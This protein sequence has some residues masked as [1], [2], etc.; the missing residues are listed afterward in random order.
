MKAGVFVHIGAAVMAG[1][2][3]AVVAGAGEIAFGNGAFLK[4]L[5]VR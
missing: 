3:G 5:A 2:K 4:E 1:V